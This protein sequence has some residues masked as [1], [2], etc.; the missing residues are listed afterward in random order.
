MASTVLAGDI[1]KATPSYLLVCLLLA[2]TGDPKGG[3]PATG[4]GEGEGEATLDPVCPRAVSADEVGV[5]DANHDAT[6]DVADA[7][8]TLRYL[9]AGGA[10]P[11]CLDAQDL[12]RDDLVD[13]SDG[14]AILYYL[15]TGQVELPSS[16]RMDCSAPTA[17]ADA[18]CGRLAMGLDGE[19][20]VSAAAGSSASFQVAV[21]LS[22]PDLAVDAWSFGVRAEGCTITGANDSGAA[23]ADLR[24]DSEG[25]R[26]DGF[27]RSDVVAGGLTHGA[28]LSWLHDT[29]LS[30]RD[31]PWRLLN[32]EL[33]ASAPDSGCQTCALSL[34]GDLEGAGIPVAL[35]VSAGGRSYT[36]S[37]SGLSVQ[38]CAI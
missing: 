27:A 3:G 32:L 6:V 31:E 29:T 23:I 24:L 5:A 4:E 17:I 25:H 38:I 13:Q 15:F 10:A 18:P 11:A 33:S 34:T 21:T 22:S 16:T 1:V 14:L 26:D 8:W 20:T 37:S 9:T 36:P 19:S 30:A 7:V 35:A 2:C 28:L 12:L